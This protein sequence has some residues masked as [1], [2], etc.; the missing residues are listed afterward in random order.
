[1]ALLLEGNGVNGQQS[2]KDSSSYNAQPSSTSAGVVHSNTSGKFICSSIRTPGPGGT[3][4]FDYQ[5]A[6]FIIPSST[7]FTLEMNV[8]FPDAPSG[9]NPVGLGRFGVFEGGDRAGFWLE[10]DG[11]YWNYWGLLDEKIYDGVLAADQWHHIVIKRHLSAGSYYVLAGAN[12]L[13]GSN[14]TA[15]SGAIGSDTTLRLG[16]TID[17][18]IGNL[19]LTPGVDRYAGGPGASYT[20]PTQPHPTY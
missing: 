4:T 14:S 8:L 1:M 6:R 18:Y 5:G 10:A 11:I 17:R 16:N 19:R 7:V 12:G 2:F 9:G 20:V 13:F 3:D 15:V